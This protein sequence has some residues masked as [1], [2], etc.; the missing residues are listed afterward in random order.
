MDTVTKN[1]E[2]SSKSDHKSKL[3]DLKNKVLNYK[4]S[5]RILL[6]SVVIVGIY[7]GLHLSEDIM[8][9]T[10]A[11]HYTGLLGDFIRTPDGKILKDNERTNLLLLGKGGEGHD[12]PDLTDT[13]IFVSVDHLSDEI[14]FISLPRDIWVKE[15]R[16]KLNSIYY[17]GNRR[18][19]TTG[20]DFVKQTV[21]EILDQPVHYAV[22]VDFT[23]FKD[24]IDIIEG[25][26]VE[27]ENS[28]VDEK[29][30]LPGKGNDLC[31]GDPS[32]GCRYE[33]ITFQSGRQ[34]MDGETAL[35]FV[36]SRNAEGDEGTDI[37]RAARQ[38]KVITAVKEKVISSDVFL[39][40]EKV[41]ALI[42][43][44][45]EH[46]ET[47][48]DMSAAAI[49][50]RRGLEAKGQISSNILP[51]DFLENP[52][53]SEEQ[54]NLYVFTPIDGDWSEIRQWVKQLLK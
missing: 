47:D 38:Q 44:G 40:R 23:A 43:T 22:V 28:F 37:A 39:S 25:I 3:F 12:S 10:G 35:K 51:E 8:E 16:A 48:L 31:D 49:L 42:S 17:W 36:R 34:Y 29:Y 9:K 5:L 50:A 52:K 45:Q 14:V 54:D 46:I 24:V 18:E 1:I 11:D 6:I 27:V 26:D 20:M 7:G 32:Y 41:N 4:R 19:E 33:T 2:K 15:Y 53:P 30:P 13:I 21:G